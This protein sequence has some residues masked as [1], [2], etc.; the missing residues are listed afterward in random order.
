MIFFCYKGATASNP[1]DGMF[2]FVPCKPFDSASTDFP[3]VK[4]TSTDLGF[5]S[6]NLNAAPK[7]RDDLLNKDLWNKVCDVVRQQGLELG[8]NFE[9]QYENTI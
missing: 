9:Y 4:L 8:V 5:I 1:Y 3:R 6:D 7:F 2:S